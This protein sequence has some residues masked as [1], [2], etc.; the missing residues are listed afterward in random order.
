MITSFAD[1]FADLKEKGIC[2]KMIAAWAVDEHTV[3]AASKAV[4]LGFVS[5]TLVG[6]A[7]MIAEVCGKHGIDISKFEI[8][9]NPDELKA[10]AQAVKMVHDGEGDVLMKGLCSTD[11]F[12]RAILNKETGLL[13]TKALLSHV[14]VIES[15]NYHKLIFLTD[16]AVVP[17]PDLKQKMTLTNYVVKVAKSFG[18][19]KPKVA[20]VAASEQVLASMPACLEAAALAKMADRGQIKG[21]IADGPLALDV[22]IDQESVEIK[23][24]TSPVAGDADCLVLP[25]IESANVFWKTNSKLADGVRQAEMLVGTTAP[26]ILASRADSVDTKLNSIAEAVLSVL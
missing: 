26:C 10:V 7:K 6:D 18:I 12:L 22:A 25:N 13:A 9:D 15:P 2:K 1:V 11:K 4:D 5:A 14:G 23:K 19:A 21:C 16:M 8:V 3:E 24:L 20:F 17:L